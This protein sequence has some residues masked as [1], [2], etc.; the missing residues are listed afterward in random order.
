[1]KKMKKRWHWRYVV[2]KETVREGTTY[3]RR[4]AVQELAHCRD[5][6]EHVGRLAMAI[7]GV[8]G[9]AADYQIERIVEEKEET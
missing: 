6:Y 9:A 3:W 2:G 1:M 4:S 5:A 8:P 7:I